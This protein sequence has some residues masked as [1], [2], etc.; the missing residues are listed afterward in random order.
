MP[1]E[2]VIALM[3]AVILYFVTLGIVGFCIYYD[4]KPVK[5]NNGYV[6]NTDRPYLPYMWY[7]LAPM[8][9]SF[10]L[11]GYAL[12]PRDHEIDD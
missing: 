1:W 11:T 4:N 12:Y 2:R 9:L 5:D 7:A 10:I 6:I 3:I 8:F